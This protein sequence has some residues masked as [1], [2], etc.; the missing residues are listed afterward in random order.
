[1]YE[2]LHL[3]RTI[4]QQVRIAN[5]LGQLKDS[6]DQPAVVALENLHR[7][8]E[9]TVWS[10]LEV[11]HCVVHGD[12]IADVDARLVGQNDIV[13]RIQIDCEHITSWFDW[14]QLQSEVRTLK[15]KVCCWTDDPS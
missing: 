15:G 7:M 6:I 12:Q 10:K 8:N 13:A 14:M 1:M 3:T 9:C 4:D 11:F 5:L 2:Q